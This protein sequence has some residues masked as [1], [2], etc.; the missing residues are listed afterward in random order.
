MN[1]IVYKRKVVFMTP[2][3]CVVAGQSNVGKTTLVEKLIKELKKRGYKVGTIKHD[4]HGF[5]MDKQGKD[6]WRHAQA[7]ADSVMIASPN[8]VAFIKKVE[9]EW[10]LD[11]L[12]KLNQDMDL[13]LA[14]GF[15][16]SSKP[17]IEVFRSEKCQRLFCRPQELIA[18]AS[19]MQHEIPDV[20]VCDINDAVCLV[21]V[22]EEKIL[23][24]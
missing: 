5:D 21:D 23:K 1:G 19:D 6:T 14:E 24:K 12:A 15:K 4:V 7:G 16:R 13:I 11:Q 3:V 2:I 18:V 10:S 8:K 22:I 17:K 20:P 9:E